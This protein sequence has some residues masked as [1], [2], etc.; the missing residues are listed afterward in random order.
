[1]VMRRCYN[2]VAFFLLLSLAA[3]AQELLPRQS[4]E[5]HKYGY[6]DGKGNFVIAPAFEYATRFSD[7][8]AVIRENGKFGY[9]DRSGKV[10]IKPVYYKV[11]GFSEGLFRVQKDENGP[12]FF[13]DEKG[14]RI[15]EKG[16]HF[17]GN[18]HNGIAVFAEKN[19]DGDAHF[20]YIDKSGKAI[21][22]AV[23]GFA[24][25]FS[26]GVGKTVE[27][28]LANPWVFEARD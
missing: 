5:N 2:L 18:Y 12:W 17:V 4:A 25:D 13:L 6:V 10:I 8:Y 19:E 22:E 14:G 20:G 1:M 7:D 23:Y 16:F 9:I 26:D 28:L 11:G 15:S 24:Y 21:V 27:Y 3:S